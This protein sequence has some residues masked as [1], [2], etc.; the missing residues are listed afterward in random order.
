MVDRLL[1]LRQPRQVPPPAITFAVVSALVCLGYIVISGFRLLSPGACGLLSDLITIP[2]AG[3]LFVVALLRFRRGGTKR[4]TWFCLML[5][6]LL[7]TA[8]ETSWAVD[9]H[10][11]H[12][13]T[14]PGLSDVFYLAAPVPVAV[15]V[16]LTIEIRL[17]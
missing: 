15:S 2:A 13:E 7:W 12:V 4:R 11:L 14:T 8:A 6:G 9:S 1:T 10:L 3:A 16:L 5:G 17:E